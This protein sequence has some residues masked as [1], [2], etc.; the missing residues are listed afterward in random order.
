MSASLSKAEDIRDR[1]EALPELDGVAVL[2]NIRKDVKSDFDKAMAKITGASVIISWVGGRNVN[3]GYEAV[4]IDTGYIIDVITKPALRG[5]EERY[6]TIIEAIIKSLNGWNQD[7]HH[8]KRRLKFEDV[9]PIN[10]K[11]FSIHALTFKTNIDL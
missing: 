4:R 2:V 6:D 3:P 10:D 5:G 11:R 9:R 1:L 8:C 7:L